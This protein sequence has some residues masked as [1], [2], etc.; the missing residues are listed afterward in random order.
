MKSQLKKIISDKLKDYSGLTPQIINK[1][2]ENGNL[3][4]SKIN[5][6]LD[7]IKTLF[8]NKKIDI[9]LLDK[10]LN[11]ETD[12]EFENVKDSAIKR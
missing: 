1:I 3:D 7:K 4:R 9:G 11:L 5:N 12:N 10:L 6:E 8:I 2:I